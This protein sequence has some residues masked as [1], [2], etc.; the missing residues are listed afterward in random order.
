M[1]ERV[2]N[3]LGDRA[4]DRLG[5][6]DMDAEDRNRVLAVEIGQRACERIR[7]ACE[8]G[9]PAKPSRISKSAPPGLAS[10]RSRPGPALARLA[11][12]RLAPAPTRA[13]PALSWKG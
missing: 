7:E 9:E 12:P 11:A 1:G 2:D 3:R 5:D 8:S 6:G 10:S 4:D 13:G